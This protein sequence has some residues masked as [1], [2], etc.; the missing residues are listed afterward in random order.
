MV[1]ANLVISHTLTCTHT[2]VREKTS[3]GSQSVFPSFVCKSSHAWRSSL[4]RLDWVRVQLLP[5]H[6]QHHLLEIKTQRGYYLVL[7]PSVRAAWQLR[8]STEH[9]GASRSQLHH[10]VMSQC[11]PG[12]RRADIHTLI[13]QDD[14]LEE[15]RSLAESSKSDGPCAMLVRPNFYCL[16]VHKSN[17]ITIGETIQLAGS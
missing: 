17:N 6:H 5:L 9:R 3:K 16:Y 11:V 15:T 12:W 8:G 2:V 7:V 13:V 1:F 14:V 10:F 4:G